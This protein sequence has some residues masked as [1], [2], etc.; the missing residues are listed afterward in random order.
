MSFVPHVVIESKLATGGMADVFLAR[1]ADGPERGRRV[2]VKRVREELV[3]MDDLLE[4]FRRESALAL[5]LGHPNIVEILDAGEAD[6]LPYLVMEHLEGVDLQAMLA[7]GPRLS[8]AN[9][10][11]IAVSIARALTYVHAQRDADGLSLGLVHRDVSPHNVFLCR[12]GSVKLLDFGIAKTNR[13]ATATGLVRG[14]AG[15]MAPEQLAGLA[16]DHRADLFALGVVLW[17]MLAAKRL[18]ALHSETATAR[19]VREESAPPIASVAPQTPE[20]L[21]RL[22]TALLA[23]FP[24]A[25]PPAA[26]EVVRALERHL[27]ATPDVDL[28]RLLV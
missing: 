27:S 6:G 5:T 3:D 12:D 19:A 2:V 11:W 4:M 18:W 21:G 22:V 1:W 9:A 26:R 10:C 8:V 16:I 23:K 15:Y 14:K 17:E 20:D 13:V 25:R 28:A 7:R 24:V